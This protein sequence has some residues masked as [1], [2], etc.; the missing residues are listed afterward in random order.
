L[1]E[2]GAAKEAFEEIAQKAVK[3]PALA[4]NP[5]AVSYEDPLEILNK[6]S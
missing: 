2:A 3:D 6:A 4:L 1:T 5:M